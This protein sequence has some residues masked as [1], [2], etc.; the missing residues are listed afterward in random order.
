MPVSMP[1]EI[2]SLDNYKFCSNFTIG[3]NVEKKFTKRWGLMTGL[4]L[5]I[6]GMD[7]DATVKNYHINFVQGGQS[8]EGQLTGHNAT[9]EY[10]TQLVLPLTAAFTISQ[11]RIFAGLYGSIVMNS[12]FEGYAYDGYIR[13]REESMEAGDPTGKKVMIGNESNTRGNYNFSD[14]MRRWRDFVLLGAD[15]NFSRHFGAFVSVTYGIPSIH[16]SSFKVLDQKLHPMFGTLGML[17]NF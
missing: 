17:Y 2:R 4:N 16:K 1:A 7:I 11:V 14:D 8:M 10:Q 15:W 6:K 3:F 5:E 13:V 9:R 12:S